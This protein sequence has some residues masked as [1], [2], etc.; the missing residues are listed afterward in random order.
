MVFLVGLL[1][2]GLASYGVVTEY[3]LNKPEPTVKVEYI[4]TM[5]PKIVIKE[6][7]VTKEVIKEVPKEIEVIKEVPAKCPEYKCVLERQ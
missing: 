2:G 7:V 5:V 6:V 3:G 4:E 1:I